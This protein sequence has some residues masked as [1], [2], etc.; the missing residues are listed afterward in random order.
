[1]LS[2]KYSDTLGQRAIVLQVT[3]LKQPVLELKTEHERIPFKMPN[4]NTH[5]EAVAN[6]MR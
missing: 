2:V 3:Y 6:F 5:Y 4:K 1:L